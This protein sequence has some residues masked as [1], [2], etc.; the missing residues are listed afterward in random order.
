MSELFETAIANGDLLV[1]KDEVE[2]NPAFCF[3]VK[4]TLIILR[5]IS[6]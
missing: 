2:Q 5:A 3:R 4:P 1:V 6:N